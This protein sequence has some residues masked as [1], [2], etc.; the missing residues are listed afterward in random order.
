MNLA[1]IRK[2]YKSQELDES[3][4]AA[5]PL[6]QFQQWMQ[7]AL[8]SQLPE[9]TAMHL[10]TIGLNGR[11]AGRIVLLKDLENG[12]FV[13]YTNYQSRK[14]QELAQMPFASLTFHWIEMER[15]VRIEG[16]VQKTSADT[17]DAYFNSRPRE[18]R[19]GAH[20]SPQSQVIAQRQLLEDHYQKLTAK[21]GTDGEV[22]RPEHWGGYIVVPEVIEFWQGRPSRLHDRIRYT[23]KGNDWL[24]ERLAP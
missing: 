8:Q 15:Q 3:Q 10:S 9:P 7:E 21:Y 23:K 16:V 18:S 22:D 20:V 17:S 11:P 4:V 2:D 13:F 19:I 24:I 5:S 6:E 14:G 12:G 1:D